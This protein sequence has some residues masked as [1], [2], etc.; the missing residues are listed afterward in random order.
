METHKYGPEE[1]LQRHIDLK[2]KVTLVC[3]LD[4][5]GKITLDYSHPIGPGDMAIIS[6]FVERH[7]DRSIFGKTPDTQIPESTL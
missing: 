1:I 4:E 6:R 2:P 7:T 3:S 5:K